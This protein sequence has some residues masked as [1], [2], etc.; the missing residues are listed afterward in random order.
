MPEAD[1]GEPTSDSL[2]HG[3][4]VIAHEGASIRDVAIIQNLALTLQDSKGLFGSM[5]SRVLRSHLKSSLSETR[6]ATVTEI[7]KLTKQVRRI[8]I[9]GKLNRTLT[10]GAAAAIVFAE[11][12]ESDLTIEDDQVSGIPKRPSP[13]LAHTL[14]DIVEMTGNS[15]V[16]LGKAGTGKTTSVL[17]YVR[18]T[19]DR[20]S[21]GESELFPVVFSLSGWTQDKDFHNWLVTEMARI[22][23]LG[24][25]ACRALLEDE[26]I[27]LVLD[28]ADEVSSELA[29]L[30]EAINDFLAH[31]ESNCLITCRTKAYLIP[32]EPRSH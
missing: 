20:L 24:E 16:V 19:L 30:F 9:D 28:G 27:V 4:S 2:S 11:I 1:E 14:T 15:A 26:R 10:G 13:D 29:K 12:A 21:R 3:Q 8:W 25:N 7:Q 5:R 32:G 18:Q 6:P 22:Y 17:L 23:R 31:R